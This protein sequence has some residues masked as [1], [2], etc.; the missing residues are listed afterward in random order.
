MVSCQAVESLLFVRPVEST[1][2]RV[3]AVDLQLTGV[4]FMSL[5]AR[6]QSRLHDAT[7]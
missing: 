3:G 6:V 1:I 7:T 4:P 5:I 2:V